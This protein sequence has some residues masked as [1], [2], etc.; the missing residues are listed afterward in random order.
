MFAPRSTLRSTVP[1]C[2]VALAI[3]CAAPA[4]SAGFGAPPV[5]PPVGPYRVGPLPPPPPAEHYATLDQAS[6]EAELGA[7]RIAFRRVDEARGVLEP[8]RLEGPLHGVVYHS[9]LPASQRESSPYEILDCRLA[10]ALDDFAKQLSAHDVVEVVHLSMYRPPPGRAFPRD[11][12]AHTHALAIDAASFV[13]RDG[14]TL[15][16]ERDFHGR[17]G[18]PTCGAGAGP[19]PST[20]EAVELRQIVCDA[21][22]ARLFNI[23]LTPDFNWRHRNHFHLEVRPDTKWFY[24]R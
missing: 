16:V 8:I 3:A 12:S 19:H 1:A 18:A 5:M 24:L 13:K 2:F 6:C 14:T 4:S 9:G 7:R 20:P 17:I 15:V 11:P 21:A 10:L 22:D 23:A